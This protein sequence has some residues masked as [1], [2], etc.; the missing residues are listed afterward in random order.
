MQVIVIS[1]RIVV[2]VAARRFNVAL[3]TLEEWI[4]KSSKYC[5]HMNEEDFDIEDEEEGQSSEDVEM[6]QVKICSR[7]IQGQR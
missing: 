2:K 3:S 1:R 7:C 6:E 4:K 5:D